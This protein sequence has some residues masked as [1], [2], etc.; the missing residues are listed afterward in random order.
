MEKLFEKRFGK[1][2]DI[3]NS[4]FRPK[5]TVLFVFSNPKKPLNICQTVDKLT[6][7]H[8]LMWIQVC[9]GILLTRKE[10][11]RRTI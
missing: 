11:N 1:C 4:S 7:I 9:A 6:E 10:C 8:V 3:F 5:N 2:P